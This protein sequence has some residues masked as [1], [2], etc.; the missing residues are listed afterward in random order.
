MSRK[1]VSFYRCQHFCESYDKFVE[2]N[3][4]YAIP[5][6]GKKIAKHVNA[7]I[8]PGSGLVKQ[9]AENEGIDKVELWVDGVS[10]EII[11]ESE[12]YSLE[13]N[14]TSY[15]D[16]TSHTITV[17]SYDTNGNMTDSS[18]VILI[19]DNSNSRP[20]PVYV[21]PVNYLNGS[22]SITWS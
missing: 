13:W 17:R 15:E 3:Y 6:K 9:Q 12:P 4:N 16:S 18:P 1:A 5:K 22:F 14:T 7:M 11:D 10:I 2:G 8:V 21:Y 19:V 20:N